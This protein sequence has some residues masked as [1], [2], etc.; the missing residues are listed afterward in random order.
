MWES[1]VTVQ[2]HHAVSIAVGNSGTD[3]R[4]LLTTVIIRRQSGHSEGETKP[5]KLTT[6]IPPW[7]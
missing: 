5:K 6:T 1:A 7:C 3:A 4:D 2:L